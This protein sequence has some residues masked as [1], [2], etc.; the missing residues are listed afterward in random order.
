MWQGPHMQHSEM[1]VNVGEGFGP[2]HKVTSQTTPSTLAP[3][4]V[5][6]PATDIVNIITVSCNKDSVLLQVTLPPPT[7]SSFCL[8]PLSAIFVCSDPPWE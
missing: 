3:A 2:V 5:M 6:P 1:A 4:G 7:V 8:L